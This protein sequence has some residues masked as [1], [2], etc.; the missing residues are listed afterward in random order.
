MQAEICSIQ[1][2]LLDC[3]F[4]PATKIKPKPQ[5]ITALEYSQP[6]FTTFQ[7][8]CLPTTDIF[9]IPREADKLFKPKTYLLVYRQQSL[10]LP[11]GPWPVPTCSLLHTQPLIEDCML[12]QTAYILHGSTKVTWWHMNKYLCDTNL[13]QSKKGVM[14][15]TQNVTSIENQKVENT[16]TILFIK[17]INRV[18]LSH[19]KRLSKILLWLFFFTSLPDPV[20]AFHHTKG[21]SIGSQINWLYRKYITCNIFWKFP[22]STTMWIYLMSLNCTL[23]NG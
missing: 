12:S 8:K 9:S 1:R 15:N 3:Y 11:E 13:S 4:S 20:I 10:P 5:A 2:I 18:P 22:E 6:C 7:R 14:K 21:K 16:N 23:R 17:K 19:L